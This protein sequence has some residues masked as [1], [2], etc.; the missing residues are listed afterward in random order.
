MTQRVERQIQ[1]A[2]VVGSMLSGVKF[3][4]FSCFHVVK[5]SDANIATFN[6]FL[7]TSKRKVICDCAANKLFL[8]H[9]QQ[10][11]TIG[12]KASMSVVGRYSVIQANKRLISAITQR[13]QEMYS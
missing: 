13:T 10:M 11:F 2:E 4:L 1:V 3:C 9:I 12:R 5:V 8:R 7:K 6:Y